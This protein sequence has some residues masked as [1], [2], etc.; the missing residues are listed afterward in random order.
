[1]KVSANFLALRVV[2]G[3]YIVVKRCLIVAGMKVCARFVVFKL[4]CLLHATPLR[5]PPNIRFR[6]T[7]HRKKR[8]I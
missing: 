5:R 8:N 6:L 7:P 3:V 4:F 2:V 1:M